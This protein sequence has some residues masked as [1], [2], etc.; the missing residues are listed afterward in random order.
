MYRFAL[1]EEYVQRVR[2]RLQRIRAGDPLDGAPEPL[3]S[4]PTTAEGRRLEQRGAKPARRRR[5][6]GSDS[7]PQLPGF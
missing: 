2:E 7:A 6:D 1:S 4:A 3:V 5:R